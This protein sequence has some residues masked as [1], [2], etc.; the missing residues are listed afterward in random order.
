MQ[1]TE[2]ESEEGKGEREGGEEEEEDEE[3]EK[4]LLNETLNGTVLSEESIPSHLM[5]R[6]SPPSHN[7]RTTPNS[8]TQLI[9]DTASA[10]SG[11]VTPSSLKSYRSIT[12]KTSLPSIKL[13]LVHFISD[14]ESYVRGNFVRNRIKARS[15]DDLTSTIANFVEN[16]T[17]S[18]KDK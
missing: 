11:S 3:E 13:D 1:S 12:S 15:R 5:I 9:T 18:K 17:E 16:A 6:V 4:G 7:R 10:D 14:P 2:E 8:V